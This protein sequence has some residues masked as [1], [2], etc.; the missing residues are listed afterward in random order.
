M[1]RP[2]I[3]SRHTRRRLK[4]KLPV[5]NIKGADKMLQ[6]SEK[7]MPPGKLSLKKSYGVLN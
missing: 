1:A 7:S 4:A 2:E 3:K 6:V 5:L